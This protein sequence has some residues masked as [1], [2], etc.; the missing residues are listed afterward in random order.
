MHSRFFENT[1]ADLLEKLEI[2]QDKVQNGN[3]VQ[4]RQTDRKLGHILQNSQMLSADVS[5]AYDPL[6]ETY[7]EKKNA[8]YLSEGVV[9]CKYSGSGGKAGGND[10]SAEYMAK[11]RRIMD[12]A[13]GTGGGRQRRRRNDRI[14][15]CGIWDGCDRLRTGGFGHACA[16][17]SAQQ[18]RFI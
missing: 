4:K 12:E 1:V 10:A 15:S 14:Y 7:F 8:A 3:A 2:R 5:A 17:G 11:L 9:F 13:G 6:Y 16:V 18:S